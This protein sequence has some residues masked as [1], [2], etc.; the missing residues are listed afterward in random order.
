MVNRLWARVL[1]PGFHEQYHYAHWRGAGERQVKCLKLTDPDATTSPEYSDFGCLRRSSNR[2]GLQRHN[3]CRGSRHS[4]RAQV[5]MAVWGSARGANGG[6]P[7]NL[8]S[9]PSE[10]SRRC[11]AH[12]L[13]SDWRIVMG[14]RC[15]W[16]VTSTTHN[17]KRENEDPPTPAAD[18]AKR[19]VFAPS[20]ARPKNPPA[21]RRIHHKNCSAHAPG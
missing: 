14:R 10:R 16:F 9:S 1:S 15:S 7:A 4:P 20:L 6:A 13:P 8:G 19:N 17:P 5:G 21:V 12:G 2:R 3:G 18:R 11:F